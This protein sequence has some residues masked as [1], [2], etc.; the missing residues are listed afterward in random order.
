MTSWFMNEPI[1]ILFGD[2]DCQLGQ[3]LDFI[4]GHASMLKL[5]QNGKLKLRPEATLK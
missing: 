3:K 2:V 5:F 4:F 1:S